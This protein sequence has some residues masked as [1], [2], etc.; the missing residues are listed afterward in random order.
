MKKLTKKG[1]QKIAIIVMLFSL[2]PIN[3]NVKSGNSTAI[4]PF[5]GITILC[6]ESIPERIEWAN[7]IA[8]KLPLIGI[9]VELMI[10]NWSEIS[11]RTWGYPGPMPIPTHAEGGFDALFIFSMLDGIDVD[12]KGCYDTP[13]L[14]PNGDNFYQYFKPEMD[15]A[16]GN[17]S[18]SFN[19]TDR[20][21]W[22]NKIQQLLYD[23]LP[24]IAINNPQKLIVFNEDL[25]GSFDLLYHQNFETIENWEIPGET[26]LHIAVPERFDIFHIL[27][28]TKSNSDA[29]WLK[30]IYAGLI[31]RDSET[32]GW[33]NRIATSWNSDDGI[34][35][36]VQ[37]N[38]NAVFADGHVLNATDVNYTYNLLFDS[39]FIDWNGYWYWGPPYFDS[40]LITILSEFE[41][42][43]NFLQSWVFQDNSLNYGIVPKHIWESIEPQDQINQS[44]DWALN[45]TLDSNLLGAG[46]YYLDD[47]DNST[48]VI[49][50]KLNEYF[51]NWTGISPNFEYLYF[52]YYPSKESAISS[53]EAGNVD[54]IDPR[55][56]LEYDDLQNLTTASSTVIDICTTQELALNLLHPYYG[57]GELCPI[58]SAESAKHVRKAINYIIPRKSIV[59]NITGG[60]SVPAATPWP[61]GSFGFNESLLPIEFNLAKAWE[62][63]EAAG[64]VIEEQIGST[65][66]FG[67]DI[68]VIII[69]ALAGGGII[70][71]YKKRRFKD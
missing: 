24:A 58:A 65:K 26:E 9:D 7:L 39:S 55:F 20:L 66:Q 46:P 45:N 37:M 54:L 2:I 63:M 43:M 21:F 30:Q 70:I 22:A 6:P 28:D 29:L 56:D 67:F 62:H 38:P 61:K 34:T 68:Q 52:E 51:K 16:I 41:F 32:L 8:E 19:Q 4:K 1:W 11:Q 15:W 60:L 64:F 36:N 35:Y 12:P 27:K 57:T 13:S 17:H 23:D 47:F 48:G 71:F 49:R 10:T 3:Y 69:P 53:F 59:Q 44:R 31:I 14:P 33:T 25:E 40:D 50:L 5:F 18:Q 42:Q